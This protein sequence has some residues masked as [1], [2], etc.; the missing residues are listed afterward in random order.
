MTGSDE[1]ASAGAPLMLSAWLLDTRAKENSAGLE[2][3]E[4]E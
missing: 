3:N 2:K 1:D 4:Y